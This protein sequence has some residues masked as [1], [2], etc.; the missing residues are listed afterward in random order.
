M[1]P[2][3]RLADYTKTLVAVLVVPIST[4]NPAVASIVP[5]AAKAEEVVAS[6]CCGNRTIKLT[7]KAQAAAD[8][9]K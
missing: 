4:T 3:D 5:P 9:L 8:A 7:T 6:L 1:L 2:A